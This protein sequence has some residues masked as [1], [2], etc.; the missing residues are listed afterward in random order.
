MNF[1]NKFDKN[2]SC[3]VVQGNTRVEGIDFD[4]TFVFVIRL[5]LI[6][7]LASIVCILDLKL[8]QMDAKNVFLNRHLK[9]ELCIT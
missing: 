4:K 8:Y 7:M 2:K 5:E 3:L 1:Q 6:H 9:E